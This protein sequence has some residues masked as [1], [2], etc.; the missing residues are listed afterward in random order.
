MMIHETLQLLF[1][2]VIF[3]RYKALSWHPDFVEIKTA[4]K[5]TGMWV[6]KSLTLPIDYYMF[7]VFFLQVP[8]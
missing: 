8:T 3:R 5:G 2:T 1:H 6:F 7:M 4:G